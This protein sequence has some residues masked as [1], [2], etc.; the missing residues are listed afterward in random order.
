MTTPA[1]IQWARAHGS[2]LADAF[3]RQ[4]EGTDAALFF[5]AQASR[6]ALLQSPAPAELAMLKAAAHGA[7]KRRLQTLRTNRARDARAIA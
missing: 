3:H 7:F 1:L 5:E 6:S 2:A 4:P